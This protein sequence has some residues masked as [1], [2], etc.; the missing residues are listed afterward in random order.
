MKDQFKGKVA[1]VTGGTQG[2][3]EA[4]ARLF[5]ERGAAGIVISGRNEERGRA[6]SADLTKGGCRAEF[7]AGDLGDLAVCRAVIAKADQA[8]AKLDILVNAAAITDRGTLIDTSPGTLR[9]DVRHQHPRPVLPDAG[10][11]ENHDPP[12]DRG[13]DGQHPVDGGAWRSAAHHRLFRLQGGA[14]NHHE[15]R[16]L[17]AH[18]QPHSRQCAE[19]RLDGHA[20]RGP[21]PASSIMAAATTGWRGRKRRRRSAAS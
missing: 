8:F 10:C 7:V 15:E 13:D 12:Q 19:Y 18:A 9:P 11:R 21:H 17:P 6:V 5:A 1:V 3:G 14:R 2:L 20:G 16:R 4:I